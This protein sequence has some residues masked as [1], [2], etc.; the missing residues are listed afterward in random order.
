MSH[1]NTDTPGAPPVIRDHPKF[2]SGDFAL[3]TPDG[4]RFRVDERYL[5]AAR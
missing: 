2:G 5:R 4:F 1:S 3:V